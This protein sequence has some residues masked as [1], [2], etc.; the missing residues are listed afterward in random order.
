VREC[1][2]GFVLAFIVCIQAAFKL[3]VKRLAHMGRER[4]TN[5]HTYIHTFH[6]TISGNQTR[7]DSSN[8]HSA[9]FETTELY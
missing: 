3:Q 5:I 8:E 4:Q 6:K 9:I 7:L 1:N 2:I